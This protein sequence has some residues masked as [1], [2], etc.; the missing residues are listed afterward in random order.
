M[1]SRALAHKLRICLLLCSLMAGVYML[2]FRGLMQSGDTLRAFDAVTSHARYGDWLMDESAF[3]GLP[4]RIREQDKLRLS[5]Y[6]V[7]EKLQIQLAAPLLHLAQSLPRL[8]NIHAVWLFNVIVTSLL[9]GL[10]YLLTRALDYADSVALLVAISAGLATNLW[11]YSQAFF[12]EPLTAL[13]LAAAF[14]SLQVGFKRDLRLRALSW[15]G[16]A[17]ALALA[18][19]VKY[20]AALAL[21]A[22][23]CFALPESDNQPAWL[24]KASGILAALLMVGLAL[25]MLI[26]PLPALLL[27]WLASRGLDGSYISDALRAYLLSPGRKCL[28][29][30]ACRADCRGRLHFAG[31][32]RTNGAWS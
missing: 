25:P 11:A 5:P 15:L 1:P 28:G 9:V 26:D 14:L 16:A 22:L 21:P 27:D 20:S 13:F 7:D 6:D 17:L 31:A 10:I 2:G 29:Y 18:A 24:R 12:R 3:Y 4:L 30:I 23:L 19:Q 32:A 8:G